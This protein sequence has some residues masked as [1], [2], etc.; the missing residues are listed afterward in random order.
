VEDTGAYEFKVIQCH[1]FWF[2]NKNARSW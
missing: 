2:Q 1:R